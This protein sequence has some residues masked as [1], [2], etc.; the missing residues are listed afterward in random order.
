MTILFYLFDLQERARNNNIILFIFKFLK[1]S[2]IFRYVMGSLLLKS[3]PGLIKKVLWKSTVVPFFDYS[4]FWRKHLILNFD[5]RVLLLLAW[6]LLWLFKLLRKLNLGLVLLHQFLIFLIQIILFIEII[7]ILLFLVLII[8]WVFV[9][10]DC[11]CI[12][13]KRVFL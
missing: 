12:T 7:F 8:I 13:F 9:G 5:F 3:L 4:A 6:L 1:F 11:R 2:L 10:I